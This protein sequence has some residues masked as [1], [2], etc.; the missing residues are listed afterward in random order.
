MRR[1]ETG[2]S[3]SG[4]IALD[5]FQGTAF[6]TKAYLVQALKVVAEGMEELRVS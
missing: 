6:E 2:E 1:I 4:E 3:Y 5:Q